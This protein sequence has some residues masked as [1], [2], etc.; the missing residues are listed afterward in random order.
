[1]IF[2]KYKGFYQIII[3]NIHQNSLF[4][5]LQFFD[6]FQREGITQHNILIIHKK[7]HISRFCW[8]F[9]HNL[10]YHIFVLYYSLSPLERKLVVFFRYNWS[11]ISIP[12][13]KKPVLSFSA[14]HTSSASNLTQTF[15]ASHL[16]NEDSTSIQN[17][18]NTSKKITCTHV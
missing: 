9:S 7:N 3:F 6:F 8:V 17:N 18:N 14:D 4:E 1:M 12:T 2:P 13:L 5:I 16:D 10:I 15:I 11:K